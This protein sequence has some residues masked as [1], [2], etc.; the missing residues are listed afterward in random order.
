MRPHFVSSMGSAASIRSGQ[1]WL[2]PSL[3]D[4]RMEFYS[5]SKQH[6]PLLCYS[7]CE[8][9][10]PIILTEP[11]KAPFVTLTSFYNVGHCCKSK[12]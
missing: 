7:P 5:I 10:L 4:P 3:Q 6:I 12:K 9:V 11:P 8:D 2:W 1:L